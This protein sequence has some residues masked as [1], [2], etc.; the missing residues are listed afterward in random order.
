MRGI[1]SKV[2]R[3]CLKRGKITPAKGLGGGLRKKG[4]KRVSG[5]LVRDRR[6]PTIRGNGFHMEQMAS[7]GRGVKL[8]GENQ[9]G[10]ETPRK[11][12]TNRKTSKN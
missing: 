4:V 8:K 3:R 10:K 5:T 9:K 12:G 7:V 11:V 6:W 2:R 1:I